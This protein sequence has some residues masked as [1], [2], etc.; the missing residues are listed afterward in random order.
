MPRP[1]QKLLLENKLETLVKELY[2]RL[3]LQLV[4][5]TGICVAVFDQIDDSF[6]VKS[7]FCD[8]NLQNL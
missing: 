3:S 5:T 2:E 7:V 8:K 6:Y 1:P 4:E